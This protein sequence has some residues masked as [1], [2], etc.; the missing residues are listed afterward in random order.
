[1]TKTETAIHIVVPVDASV[2]LARLALSDAC[3]RYCDND[4]V[5]DA[6]YD[7]LKAL[8]KVNTAIAGGERHGD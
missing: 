2:E 6:L 8:A 5:S 4:C 7:A 1:M 3:D